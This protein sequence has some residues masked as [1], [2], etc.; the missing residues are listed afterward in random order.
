[1]TGM[2]RRAGG[3]D[4]AQSVGPEIRPPGRAHGTGEDQ[5]AAPAPTPAGLTALQRKAGNRAVTG[6]V[7]S[8]N[9]PIQRKLSFTGTKWSGAKYLDASRGGGG[10]VLFAGEA[11]KEIVVKPGED[12]AAEGALA[13]MLHNKSGKKSSGGGKG[14]MSLGLAPGLRVVDPSEAKQIKSALTPL[15]GT[16][17]RGEAKPE[18]A[19]FK[20]DRAAGL[21]SKLD[22]PGVVVQDLA[23]GMEMAD[24]MKGV[25]KHTE[26]RGLFGLGSGRKLRKDSPL[27]IFTD[28]RAIR[29]LG[30]NS[31]ID[32]FTGNKDR[33]LSMYNDQNF[34]VSPYSVTMIDNIWMGTDMSY[35]Q[36]TEIEGHGGK[37]FTITADAGIREWKADGQVKSLVANDYDAIANRVWNNI[38]ENAARGTRGTDET[39]FQSVMAPHKATFLKEF[40]AGLA[41]GKSELIRSLNKLIA[42]PAKFQRLVPGVD[43]TEIISTLKIRRDFLQGGG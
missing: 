10:G 30:S 1:M 11:T 16:V 5:T 40:S 18:D 36:T 23:G 29:A 8:P 13:A 21:L 32:L 17:G 42:N 14:G 27:R 43:L 39:A 24:A 9:V 12:M 37:K 28:P 15:L 2:G 20:K 22:S 34:M 19:K 33:L 7:A 25:A 31:A 26:K 35:F 41:S 3:H 38:V 6:L 4:E